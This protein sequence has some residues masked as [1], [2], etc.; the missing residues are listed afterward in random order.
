VILGDSGP[1]I[2]AYNPNDPDHDRCVRFIAS[3]AEVI[4]F[5]TPIVA[6]VGHL[7][8]VASGPAA[9]ARFLRDIG[10]GRVRLHEAV[11]MDYLRA[12]ELVSQYADFPLGA[13]DA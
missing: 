7:L 1:A 5:P 11:E 6:E 8:Q 10:L 13:V 4:L 2:A 9:E 3:T 12:A